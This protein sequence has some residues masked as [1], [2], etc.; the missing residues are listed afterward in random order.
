MLVTNAWNTVVRRAAPSP[1]VQWLDAREVRD[2][3]DGPFA[4]DKIRDAMPDAMWCAQQEIYGIQVRVWTPSAAIRAPAAC[5]AACKEAAR[6]VSWMIVLHAGVPPPELTAIDIVLMPHRKSMKAASIAS[7]GPCHMNSGFTNGRHIVIYRKQQW[8]KVL[9]HEM[10]HALGI[11]LPL[12]DHYRIT[13]GCKWYEAWVE[14]LACWLWSHVPCGRACDEQAPPG[15]HACDEHLP[16]A[17]MVPGDAACV[18]HATNTIAY[19]YGKRAL[20]DD[21]ARLLRKHLALRPAIG[22]KGDPDAMVRACLKRI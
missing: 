3:M 20:L 22:F 12:V 11:D 10:I 1:V 17:P 19:T 8:Q 2:A 7:L 13:P 16:D 14:A 4:C 6:I 18:G 9:I 15:G 21:H 5:T